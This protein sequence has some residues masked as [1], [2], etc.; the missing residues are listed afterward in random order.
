[1]L[2]KVDGGEGARKRWEG[3]PVSR[4]A[5]PTWRSGEKRSSPAPQKTREKPAAGEKQWEPGSKRGTNCKVGGKEP[6]G[7]GPPGKNGK[8]GIKFLREGT[9]TSCGTT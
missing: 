5:C 9:R 3:T 7:K 4:R 6:K 1:L 8:W 2:G